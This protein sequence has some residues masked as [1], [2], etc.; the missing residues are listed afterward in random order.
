VALPGGVRVA[1]P[2]GGPGGGGGGDRDAACLELLREEADE[3]ASPDDWML[4]RLMGDMLYSRC[5]A[6]RWLRMTSIS[7]AR[8]ECQ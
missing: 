5:T 6:K 2:G 4:S 3:T 8:M 7:Q 1:L